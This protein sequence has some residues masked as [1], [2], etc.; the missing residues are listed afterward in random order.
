[1]NE[2]RAAIQQRVDATV[3][4][5]PPIL[6]TQAMEQQQ[7]SDAG[8][9]SA[10]AELESAIAQLQ[11]LSSRP[12]EMAL[13][14]AT[15]GSGVELIEPAKVPTT[16]VAPKPQRAALLTGVAGLLAGCLVVWF[17]AYR[18][19]AAPAPAARPGDESGS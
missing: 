12:Q 4:A 3:P 6:R 11:E 19:G 1:V 15:L 16:P 13:E 7:A 10:Q 5:V 8:Y 14:A 9:I 17:Q 18:K 2:I